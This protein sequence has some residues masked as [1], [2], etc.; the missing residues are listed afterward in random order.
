LAISKEIK[1][2]AEG[3][4][5][6]VNQYR[7]YRIN[8]YLFHTKGLE[9]KRVTQNS[10]VMAVF[11]QNCFS[12]TR[13]Q[14]P[15]VG[16]IIYYGQLEEIVEIF[17]AYGLKDQCSYVMFKVRWCQS[18]KN[19]DEYG[20]NLVNL[21]K[22]IYCNEKFMF[23]SQADQCFYV[24]DPLNPNAWVI[25]YKEPRSV[26]LPSNNEDDIDDDIDNYDEQIEAVDDE[27]QDFSYPQNITF[28]IYASQKRN[29]IPS[30][31]IGDEN[32][33]R[34]KRKQTAS[35]I[36]RIIQTRSRGNLS[37]GMYTHIYAR[38]HTHTHS[39]THAH[40]YAHAHIH[41]CTHAHMHMHIHI[42]TSTFTYICT[43]EHMHIY[44]HAHTYA[45]ML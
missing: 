20:F 11:S 18:E 15:A 4:Y 44:I 37:S 30:V 33:A 32:I 39:W 41:T 27:W 12:S 36:A 42:F 29:D 38:T 43:H 31:V 6:A 3:P 1:I 40:T 14:N 35:T 26:I 13:D 2:H 34:D 7:G 8:G 45:H 21:N 5:Y 24:R 23:A 10:G 25:L 22:E 19:K 17:Y 9:E 16:D 28:D